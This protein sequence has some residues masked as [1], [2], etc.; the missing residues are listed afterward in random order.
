MCREFDLKQTKED[1]T[2]ISQLRNLNHQRFFNVIIH[3]CTLQAVLE[4]WS[5]DAFECMTNSQPDFEMYNGEPRPIECSS[6]Q[7]IILSGSAS[8]EP[9]GKECETAFFF[10]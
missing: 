5:K 7:E 10:F 2:H 4:Q 8:T 9:T 3:L 1:T 6:L